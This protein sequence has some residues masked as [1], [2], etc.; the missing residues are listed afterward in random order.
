MLVGC[1]QNQISIKD[2][3]VAVTAITIGISLF[4]CRWPHYYVR[5][6]DGSIPFGHVLIGLGIFMLS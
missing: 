5:L 3:S 2:V 4:H 1:L 6:A